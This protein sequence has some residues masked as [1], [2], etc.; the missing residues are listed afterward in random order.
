MMIDRIGY[1]EPI[2]SGKRPGRNEPVTRD[3]ASDSISLSSEA[4]EKADIYRT[5]DLVA[6]APDARAERVMELKAKINDPSYLDRRALEAT[7]DKIMEAF[8]L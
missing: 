7:A 1:T 4:L 2:Q 8:G 5:T 3:S 6:A